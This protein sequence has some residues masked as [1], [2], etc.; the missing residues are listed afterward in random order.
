MFSSYFLL[1]TRLEL[2]FGGITVRL[3][4]SYIS[5]MALADPVTKTTESMFEVNWLSLKQ[6]QQ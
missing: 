1:P 3:K 2:L 4:I 6:L 5:P